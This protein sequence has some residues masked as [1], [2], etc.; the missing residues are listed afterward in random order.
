MKCKAHL[1][2]QFRQFS[3]VSDHVML[4]S[5]HFGEIFDNPRTARLG[6]PVGAVMNPNCVDLHVFFFNTATKLPLGQA[7]MIVSS[8]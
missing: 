4:S 8:I 2:R 1:R 5:G 7:A 3:Q 6:H